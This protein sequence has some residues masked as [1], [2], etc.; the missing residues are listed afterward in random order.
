MSRHPLPP[1]W[2]AIVETQLNGGDA[3]W[4]VPDTLDG[5]VPN[6]PYYSNLINGGTWIVAARCV[7]PSPIEDQFDIKAGELVPYSI[8]HLILC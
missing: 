4:E 7:K 5:G 3:V 6:E 2:L 1:D 8:T